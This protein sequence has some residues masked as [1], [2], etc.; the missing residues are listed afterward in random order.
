MIDTSNSP[1][2]SIDPLYTLPSTVSIGGHFALR[3]TVCTMAEC[4][5]EHCA[6]GQYVQGE[7]CA[8]GQYAQ[9]DILPS[10]LRLRSTCV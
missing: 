8:V 9:G 1:V 6:V 5:G 7:H 10:R 4:P 2:L 3:E